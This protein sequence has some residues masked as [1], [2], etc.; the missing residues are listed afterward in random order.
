M[1]GVFFGTKIKIWDTSDPGAIL[2]GLF[3]TTLA[4]IAGTFGPVFGFLAGY[5][6]LELVMQICELHGGVSLYNNGFAGGIIAA[7]MITL[8]KVFNVPAGGWIRRLGGFGIAQQFRD[9]QGD[10]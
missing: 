4:P 1:A 9:H 5:L 6:H 10:C 3:C 2:A 7:V 8:A